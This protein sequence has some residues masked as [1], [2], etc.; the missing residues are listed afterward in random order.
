MDTE[1]FYDTPDA[2]VAEY[3][4]VLQPH[5]DLFNRIMQEKQAFA[6]A[7]D[8]SAAVYSKPHITLVKMVQRV[9]SEPHWLKRVAR[10]VSEHGPFTVTLENYGSFPT[11]SIYLQVKTKTAIVSLVKALRQHG[12]YLYY[13]AAYKPHFITEPHLT[14]ARKL[15]PW[16]Y[17]QAW[18]AYRH[19]FFSGMF[20]AKEVLLLRRRLSEKNYQILERFA[21]EGKQQKVV[22]GG[23]F[24]MI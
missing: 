5:E 22:Q 1:Q 17:E 24:E 12:K 2:A 11:H 23:L 20:L 13:D 21:L 15:L 7:Y 3:L 6:T 8:C 16:Q 19:Q 4:L 10:T 9:W 14:I 18:Q